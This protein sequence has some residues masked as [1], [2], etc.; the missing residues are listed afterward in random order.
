MTKPLKKITRKTTNKATNIIKSN[1]KKIGKK[2]VQSTKNITV[3]AMKLVSR[4]VNE[5]AKIILSML[6]TMTPI[7]IIIVII[8]AFCSFFGIGMSEDT[9]NKYEQYMINTQN[10]YD[11][12]TVDFYNQGNIVDGAIEGRGMINWKVP[13]SIIQ[14]LNGK[15][16]YDN[17][18]QELLNSFKNAELFEKVTDVTYTYEKEVEVTDKKGNTDRKSVV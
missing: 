8:V 7:I 11:N 15:L 4:L 16:V 9:R 12:I 17:A 14:V 10:E 2:V 18:E 3:N 1:S 5:M 6:P 13:L